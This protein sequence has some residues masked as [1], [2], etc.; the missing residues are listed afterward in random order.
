M[1]SSPSLASPVRFG[2]F[3]LDLRAG[4][5]RRDGARVPLAEQPLRLL[6]VLLEHPGVVVS[7]EQLRQRLW[8]ADT[9]VDFEHGLNAAV[10]RLRDALGDAAETPRFIETVP[11]RGYRF[12]APTEGSSRQGSGARRHPA[13]RPLAWASAGA[14]AALLVMMIVGGRARRSEAPGPLT[15]TSMVVEQLNIGQPGIHFA[16]SP[17]GRTV[18]FASN[19]HGLFRRDLDRVDPVPIE[20]TVDGSDVF[21]SEDGRSIGFETRSEL[22]T[23]SL[24]GGT[25]RML[26]PNQPLRGGSWGTG[27][28]IV[29]GRVGSGLW[30]T[31]VSGGEPRQLTVPAEGE[32]HEL[33]Q[34]LPGG[35]VV[36]FTILSVKNPSRAAIYLLDTGE[37]RHLFEGSSARFIESGHIVFGRQGKL[38]AVGFDTNSLQTRGAARS[39]R[40]DVR[41][42]AAGYPQFAIDGG[43]LAYVR[44]SEASANLGKVVPTL[45]NRQGRPEV[46]AL[47]ADHYLLPRFSPSGDRLVVQ[48]GATRDLWIYDLGRRT[49]TRLTSDRIVAFS[50]PAWTPDGSHIVFTTWFDGEVGLGWVPADGSG[51]V[52][53]LVKGIGL[54]SFER[55]HPAILPDTSGVILTG[56]A[57]GASSED[58]LI[59]RLTGEKRLDTL[60]EGPGVARNPAIAS[61]GRFVAYNSDE[62]GRPEVYV[63]PFPDIATR[64]WQVSAEGG[65]FPVWT[66][67]G[68]ELVYVDGEG[69]IM[70]AA[71]R[72]HG[73][74]ESDFSRPEPLFTFGEGMGQGLDRRFDVTS[75]GKRFVFLVVAGAAASEPTAELVLIQNW[76]QE[77]K[78]LVPPEP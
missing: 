35:R 74:D 61:S 34:M 38:W 32:R 33:P 26:L 72:P 13:S 45:V 73:F 22:W 28:R 70:A 49:F 51:P 62:S 56:L 29:V 27:D 59:A 47:P 1:P 3:E 69:R 20:G 63:R 23:T 43:L 65:A 16:V 15:V 4:E 39:V 37:T 71:V 9:F 78:R 24:D 12:V 2:D 19:S 48:V 42:S 41:W 36:L 21:F 17:G 11:K 40:D 52:E 75:D 54:R 44:T 66:R 76:V 46:L 67:R 68:R 8:P 30:M 31:S 5:L 60:L 55:T 25:P 18:V 77:L 10:K 58:L 14:L 6:E 64:R 50:A 57:P 7:R 53:P